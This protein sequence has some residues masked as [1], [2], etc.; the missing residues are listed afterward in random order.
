MDVGFLA[1]IPPLL[2]IALAIITRQVHMALFLGVFTGCMI[3]EGFHPLG[4]FELLFD[5]VVECLTEP[6]YMQV[7]LICFLLGGLVGLL[8]RSGGSTA[9]SELLGRKIKSRKGAQG[10]TWGV[11]LAIFF[12]DYFNCLTNGSIM[13]SVADKFQLSREKFS[14]IVDSTAVG[15]CLIVPLSSWVAFIVS[16][17]SDSFDSA[18]IEADAYATFIQTV[19]FNFYALCALTMVPMVAY[20][21][22]DFGPMGRAEKRVV[23][24][25]VVCESTFTGGD[26]D[27]DDFSSIERQK[28]K[29]HDLLTPI[30]LLYVLAI[31]FVLYTGGF[32]ESFDLVDAFHEMDGLLALVYSISL[33]IIFAIIFYAVKRLSKVS[34][35]ILAFLIGT[36]SMLFVIILLTFAWSLGAICEE[37]ETADYLVDIMLG[38]VPGAVVP[39]LIFIV[40]FL[41]TFATGATW[42][43]YAIMIPMAAPIAVG[44]DASVLACIAAV[45]GAGGFG[46][47]CSPLADTTILASTASNIGIIDHIKTQVPY[48]LTCGGIASAGYLVSGALGPDSSPILPLLVVAG[49]F[50][51]VLFVFKRLSAKN[52]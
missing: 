22:L 46:A 10:A 12:D 28:G 37:L 5:I 35:S 42:G 23:T 14:Y 43:T 25:G 33:S 24:T 44:M 41:M 11:G 52:K 34:E 48:A 2:A 4:A 26:A 19:P 9:F 27:E 8:V 13:R 7:I 3:M 21:K 16:L 51:V 40:A 39:C 18:G 50:V 38:T 36:K 1:V 17:I 32:F 49:L 30:L 6:E 31:V 45:I 47:H 20:F 29:A 15:I